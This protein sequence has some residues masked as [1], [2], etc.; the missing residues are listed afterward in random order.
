M[1]VCR[2]EL[3]EGVERVGYI[4][5]QYPLSLE[6]RRAAYMDRLA[7]EFPQHSRN[8]LVSNLILPLMSF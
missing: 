8:Q 3:S 1:C 4:I 5:E 7:R 2:G 6:G